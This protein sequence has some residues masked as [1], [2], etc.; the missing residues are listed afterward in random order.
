M[1]MSEINLIGFGCLVTFI[2][3]AGAYLYLREAFTVRE[4]LRPARERT[5]KQPRAEFDEELRSFG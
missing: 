1:A 4:K 3:V 5:G 2:A